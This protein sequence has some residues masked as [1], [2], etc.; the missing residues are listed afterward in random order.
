[1][2]ISVCMAT[3]NGATYII[4][5]MNS[6]LN[7]LQV[8]DE[9]IVSDDHSTDRTVELIK[10]LN[11]DR[12]NIIY[13]ENEKGYAS[14]FE[15]AISHSTGDIIFLSDQDD[16]WVKGKVNLMMKAL[17]TADLAISDAEIVDKDLNCIEKSHFAL[18]G[19]KIGFWVN[20]TKTRYIG[21]CMAFKRHMLKKLLPMPTKRKYCAHDYWIA[22]VGEAYYKVALVDIPL[23]KYRRH[24]EN[25]STGGVRSGNSIWHKLVVRG[26]VLG[27]LSLRFWKK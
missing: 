6:I 4:E 21:A 27:Q 10:S 26:Y 2:K 14:N 23:L 1:M 16:V 19:V 15:N 24:G 7:E 5:Q 17:E 20:F 25:A 12:I 13:N 11:D 8:S 22:M 9:V 3:Y 18:F